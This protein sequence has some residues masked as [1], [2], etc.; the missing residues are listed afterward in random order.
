MEVLSGPKKKLASLDGQQSEGI[1]WM[2]RQ[3]VHRWGVDLAPGR[4][5]ALTVDFTP[6]LQQLRVMGED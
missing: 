6:M 5:S 2:L 1:S 3:S 4:G